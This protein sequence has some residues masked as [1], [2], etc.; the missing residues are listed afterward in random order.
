M[1]LQRFR[2]LLQLYICNQFQPVFFFQRLQ[3]GC[4][5]GVC[6][7]FF[8]HF[9]NYLLHERC[10]ITQAKIKQ[11]LHQRVFVAEL[12]VF[13]KHAAKVNQ[14]MVM[15]LAF[16]DFDKS[17]LPPVICFLKQSVR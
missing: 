14:P 3:V 7:Y 4:Q 6:F 11:H 17:Q 12:L 13:D 8:V 15:P 2:L 1:P 16:T 9:V 5:F 10:S